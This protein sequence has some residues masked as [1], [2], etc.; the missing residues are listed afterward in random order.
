MRK[1]V[2][3]LVFIQLGA[4][5]LACAP[6][7]LPEERPVSEKP[8]AQETR[9]TVKAAWETEWEKTFYPTDTLHANTRLVPNYKEELASYYDLL[10]PRLLILMPPEYS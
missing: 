5:V 10:N 1:I 8:P 2:S 6:K 9:A 4:L 7:G 3:L